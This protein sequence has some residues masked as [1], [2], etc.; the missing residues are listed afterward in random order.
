MHSRPPLTSENA[1]D[2]RSNAGND[3]ERQIYWY[4]KSR[5]AERRRRNAD[6]RA[7]LDAA[8]RAKR[9]AESKP[10]MLVLSLKDLRLAAG[11][12]LRQLS[13]AL[14][15]QGVRASH[16][17]LGQIERGVTQAAP[18]LQ[19]AITETL[20]RRS[21]AQAKPRPVRSAQPGAN[22]SANT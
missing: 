21:N 1:R 12:T 20:L 6:K 10:V 2:G 3:V 19:E 9:N 4:R 17:Y 14:S 22:R 13:D 16:V 7:K 11:Y 8:Y 5:E 18:E 15:D